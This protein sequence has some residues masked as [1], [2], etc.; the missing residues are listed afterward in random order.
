KMTEQTPSPAP[1]RL[2]G[3]RKGKPLRPRHQHLMQDF[4]PQVSVTLDDLAEPQKIFSHHPSTVMFEIGFGAGAAV[5]LCVGHTGATA[6]VMVFVQSFCLVISG[7]YG[8]N[9]S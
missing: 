1:L 3:R 9:I 4:L 5:C 7:I 6:R 8:V 2:Y